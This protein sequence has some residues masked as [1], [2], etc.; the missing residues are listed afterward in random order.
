MTKYL[1]ILIFVLSSCFQKKQDI[2]INTI[3]PKPQH[4][5][6]KNGFFKLGVYTNIKYDSLFSNEAKFLKNALQIKP[7]GAKNSIILKYNKNL[8]Q[9]EYL[10]NISEKKIIIESST[11]AGQIHAI[12]SLIQLIPVQY[13]KNT[14]NI[15]IKCIEIHDFP[16]FKWRGMLLDCCRHFMEKEFIK[17][18]IDLL[19]YHKMNILHWHLT[20]DQGWRIAIDKYPNLTKTGA[21]RKEKDGSIYGGFYS[22]KDIKEIVEY[23]K[24]RHIE[25]IPEIELP[26]H[27]VAAIASYPYLSC[28]GDSISVENDWGVFKDIYCAGNDSVFKFLENVLIE[29]IDLFPSEYIHI[30]GDEAPK[31]RWKECVKCQ[32]RINDEDLKDEHE[33]QSYFIKRIEKFLNTKGK[34]IIGWDEIIEGGIAPSATIQSWRGT[35]GAILAAKAQHNA[36]MSP[37]S[38]CYFDYSLDAINLKKVYSFEPIPKELDGIDSNY[39]IGGEC[40]MWTEYV[41][42]EKID[43]KVFPRILAM[44]EVLWSSKEKNYINFHKRVQNHYP[45]LDALNV[46]YGYEKTPIKYNVELKNNEFTINIEKGRGDMQLEYT[47]DNKLWKKYEKPFTIRESLIIK[48]KEVNSK[49]KNTAIKELELNH[50]KGLGKKVNYKNPYNASYIGSGTNTL[51]NGILGSDNDFRDGQWQ[52]F[53]GTDVEI[54]LDLEKEIEFSEIKTSFFQYNLS[55]IVIPKEVEILVSNNGKDFTKHDKKYFDTNPMQEDKFKKD[56]RFN[57]KNNARFIKLI[58]RNFGKLPKTHPAAGS[59]CWIFIDELIIK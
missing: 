35:N 50:H 22:K 27:C 55:W 3:I 33:L 1:F 30:G 40:N 16:R 32:K 46:D 29:V 19:S 5:I 52:G 41:P 49:R 18:Y 10:L 34:K 23:A 7:K 8:L 25:I 4:S 20:E 28:S 26:G 59:D 58:A 56:F 9:E 37:T 38:H 17:K 39:I 6:Q 45:K 36:I 54:V 12:Q 21:W 14:L 53:F 11:G 42:Q 2:N 44:S 57:K 15:P 43:S 13:N 48:T 31:Y 51:T 47:L 24:K